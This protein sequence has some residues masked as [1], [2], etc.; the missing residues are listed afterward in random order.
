[1]E[2]L[3][4]NGEQFLNSKAVIVDSGIRLLMADTSVVED[5]MGKI[6]GSKDGSETIQPGFWSSQYLTCLFFRGVLLTL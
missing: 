4:L 6:P 3:S 2:S 5:F 1:M